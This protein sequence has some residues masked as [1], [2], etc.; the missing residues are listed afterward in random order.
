MFI[1]KLRNSDFSENLCNS[2]IFKWDNV[3][4]QVLDVGDFNLLVSFQNLSGCGGGK[5]GNAIKSGLFHLN[6]LCSGEDFHLDFLI[7]V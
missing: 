7:L 5:K 3:E 4:D 6:Y 2:F 1:S